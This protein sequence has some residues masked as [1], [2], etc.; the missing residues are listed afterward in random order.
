MSGFQMQSQLTVLAM[1]GYM[2]LTFTS[3][4]HLMDRR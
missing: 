4:G 3:L 1:I 2:L